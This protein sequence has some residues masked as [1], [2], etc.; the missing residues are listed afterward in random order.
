M[1]EFF[2]LDI[3][4]IFQ[5]F[6]HI[7]KFLSLI[8][9]CTNAECD[10]LM[11]WDDGTPFQYEPWMSDDFGTVEIIFKN[12][13]AVQHAA[14]LRPMYSTSARSYICERDCGPPPQP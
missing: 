5:Q 9:F 11:V 1:L 14:T 10:G 4:A 3:P 7:L 8:A 6:L 2:F 12:R 13:P